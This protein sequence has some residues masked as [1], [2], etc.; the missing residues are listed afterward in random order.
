[1]RGGADR[2]EHA[3]EAKEEEGRQERA[4]RGG[5]VGTKKFL[6]LTQLLLIPL[7]THGGSYP[8]RASHEHEDRGK[9]RRTERQESPPNTQPIS[10]P[11]HR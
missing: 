10:Q 3:A 5:A 2:T 1:M 6:R 4:R 8:L 7:P 9:E 11:S